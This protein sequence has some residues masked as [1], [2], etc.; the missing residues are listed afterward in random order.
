MAT[1]PTRSAPRYR[2]RILVAGAGLGLAL[3]AI[4]AP[5]FNN[6]IEDDLERRVPSELAEA[7]FIGVAATFSGQDGTLLCDQPLDDPEVAISAA[8]D[9]WGVRAIELDRSCRV[10][11]APTVEP[12]VTT[13]SES[14]DDDSAGTIDTGDLEL[15][16]D[17]P[18][19]STVA[20]S[21]PAP[22]F[23]TVADIVAS[24]P[25]LSLLSVLAQEAGFGD[26][27]GADAV[28]EVTLFA[29]TDAAF[30]ALPADVIANIRAN[31]ELLRQVLDHHTVDGR[32]AS[33]DLIDGALVTRGGGSVDV[34][35]QPDLLTVGGATVTAPDL[36]AGN[37][38][39]HVI[40][41]VLVPSD[42]DLAP[43]P[44]RAAVTATFDQGGLTLDG[45]VASE[46]ERA[47]LVTSA[48]AAVGA[49][50][51]VDQLAVD[52]E[53]GLDATTAASLGQLVAAMPVQL[54]SGVSGFD[55]TE[56]YVT[57]TY[58]TEAQRD[59]MLAAVE[60]VGA[61][62]DL[63]PRPEATTEDAV[64][65]EAELNAFVLANPILFEPSS[66]TLTP[67][68]AVV[69]DEV[70]RRAQEF[71][72]VAITVEGHTDSDGSPTQNV[73]LSRL[74]ALAVRDGL[75]LRGVADGS[76]TAEGFGSERPILVDG[77]EDKAASRRVEFRVVV[78][79]P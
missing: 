35:V 30:D 64:D 3:Y 25:E 21:E 60:A 57:G 23:A 42:V 66:A 68:A 72:G 59:A 37:G 39:V 7:G 15:A 38:I 8:Y 78:A 19:A 73:T 79:T 2:L 61:M 34:V 45:T 75:V 62:S 74:R 69:I 67:E 29:P 63:Q 77:V 10:N 1:S 28:G 5:I 48:T 27:I 16:D 22:D 56:L 65:L 14:S 4:G 20:S 11:R 44:E 52:P 51:V 49:E 47:A 54:V 43:A 50:S 46:V 12:A 40:D 36:T 18:P 13:P 53:V 31:P 70:A 71:A 26:V 6:R 55:G 33:S 41:M 32:L 17:D 58:A 76:I 24:T 9:V